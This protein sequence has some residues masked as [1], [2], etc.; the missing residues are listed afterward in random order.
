MMGNSL[1][2]AIFL[3]IVGLCGV[4][5]ATAQMQT[6]PIA[7]QQDYSGLDIQVSLGWAE[8]QATSAPLAVSLLITNHSTAV[9]SGQLVLRNPQT[10]ARLDLGEATAGPGSVRHFG[11]VAQLHGWASCELWWEGPNGPLWAR[12]LSAPDGASFQGADRLLLFVEAGQRNLR[13]PSVSGTTTSSVSEDGGSDTLGGGSVA[14]AS[15]GEWVERGSKLQVIRSQ[16]WQLPVHPGPFTQL[17][18]ALLSPLVR[19]EDLTDLQW[20][21]LSQWVALGGYVMVPAES[22]GVLE[23]LQEQLPCESVAA[24]TEGLLTVHRCGL[25]AIEVYPGADLGKDG[26]PVM[27][28]IADAAATRISRALFAALRRAARNRYSNGFSWAILTAS[29]VVVLFAI[30]A[31]ATA[32][33]IFMF[34]ASRRWVF[35]WLVTVVGV[36]SVAAAVAGVVL[37]Q[38]PADAVVTTVTE[39]GEGSLVQAAS[40]KLTSAGNRESGLTIRGRRPELQIDSTNEPVEGSGFMM[41]SGYRQTEHFSW[42]PFDLRKTGDTDLASVSLPIPL[43]PWSSRTVTAVDFGPPEGQLQVKLSDIDFAEMQTAAGTPIGISQILSEEMVRQVRYQIDIQSTLPYKISE[44]TL[45]AT[46]WKAPENEQQKWS[47]YSANADVRFDRGEG[48]ANEILLIGFEQLA[49]H[50]VPFQT[51]WLTE[52]ARVPHGEIAVWLV[53]RIDRSPIIQLDETAG[54]PAVIGSGE[55]LL[56]CRVPQEN[57]PLSWRQAR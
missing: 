56:I 30:Y 37:R 8:L 5:P 33:P 24:T 9:L 48:R 54:D 19:L 13:F 44:C 25:G 6:L 39:I 55:H 52:S 46:L 14:A 42:P 26:A 34:R 21:A 17:H 40:V 38:S 36:G 22:A 51:S 57:L 7:G 16:P 29:M 45:W 53:A 27:Q 1:R 32:L 18:T 23:K 3:I 31:V 4:L 11:S 2:A 15:P 28:A 41:Y 50:Y 10:G 43:V 12:Q 35:G 49:E 47:L 20:N